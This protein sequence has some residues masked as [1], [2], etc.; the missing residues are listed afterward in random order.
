[1]LLSSLWQDARYG[2]RGLF[3]TPVFT[4]VAVLSLALGIGLNAAIFTIVDTVLFKPMPVENPAT[5]AAVFTTTE[6]G[7]P[8]GTTSYL[9]YLDLKRQNSRLLGHGRPLVD[10]HVGQRLWQKPAR[11]R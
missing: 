1:M 4:L 5:L 3:R 7:E 11:A 9:D 8:F 2:L 10:V 6:N